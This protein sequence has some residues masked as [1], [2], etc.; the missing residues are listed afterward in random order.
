MHQPGPRN[1]ITDVPGL[2]VGHCTD[3]QV[4]SGVTVLLPDTA[5][6]AGVDVRGG[7]PGVRETDVLQPENSVGI[8]H[9]LVLSGG[10]VFG[11]SAADGVVSALSPYGVG[12]KLHPET[13][14][15]PIVPAA[16]LYDL[17]NG[18]NKQWGES[19]P[20]R[21]F[22][23]LALAAASRHFSQGAVGAGTGAR[24]GIGAGGLGSVSLELGEGVVVGAL[25]V[26]NPIGSALM[27]DGETFWAWP[28]EIGGE[29]GA[30]RPKA[31]VDCRDPIPELSR[32]AERGRLQ[33]GA[34][35]TL[36]VVA[37][38]AKLSPGERKRVAMMA[39][40]GIAR[41]VRPAHLPFDGD[42]V[43][44]LA[45]GEC[46]LRGGELRLVDVARI[47]AAAADCVA[48][49]IARGVYLAREGLTAA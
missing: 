41:A 49:A 43:F 19:S 20:Y 1:A 6:D 40:D 38:N 48:R 31:P 46:E 23:K 39:H 29:F 16:V 11:L 18:G 42:T 30:R 7:G 4:K 10:S 47:G 24:A 3:A 22:G 34:N 17:H 27:P 15:T 45:S 9:A 37:V 32:L 13:P 44:V 35:T 26:A 36:A 14:A 28:L 2:R 25:V 8:V 12:L 33:P 21:E 5:W